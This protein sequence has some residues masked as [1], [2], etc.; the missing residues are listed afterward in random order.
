M[1]SLQM[2]PQAGCAATGQ[3]NVSAAS[4]AVG[5]VDRDPR[6]QPDVPEG[7]A[8]GAM[9]TNGGGGGRGHFT[10]RKLLRKLGFY[11]LKWG[12][13]IRGGSKFEI[14]QENEA[15]R[16]VKPERC[17]RKVDLE[18]VKSQNVVRKSIWNLF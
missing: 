7:T 17:Y 10:R 5:L 13:G 2:V 9:D 14:S 8:K 3:R 1:P 12:K 15:R 11:A 4:R 18:G 16:A 6:E